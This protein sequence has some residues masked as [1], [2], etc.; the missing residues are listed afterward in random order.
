MTSATLSARFISRAT[1]AFFVVLLLVGVLVFRDYGISWDEVPTRQFGLMNVEQRVP[2]LHTLD[3]VRKVSG[4]SF[5]R[6]GPAFEILLVRAE[7]V[8]QPADIRNVMY[9]RHLATF[10]VFFAGVIFFHRFCRRRFGGGLSL[11]ACVCLVASPQ[12][13]SHAFYNVKDISFLTMFVATMLTLD[14]VLARPTLRA[15]LLHVFATLLLLGARIL[16]VFAMVLTGVSALVRGPAWRT[17][18]M[19]VAYGLLVAAL[20]PLV[21][22]VLRID[23]VHIVLDAVLGTTTNPYG[24]AD[25]F[26]GQAVD[27]KAL[28]WDYVPTWMLITTP[29][30]ISA[31]FVFGV[32]STVGKILRD[33]VRHLR[34]DQQDLIVLAWFFLPVLGCMVLR[35]ILYDA[36]RHLFFVYPALVYLAAA[37]ME[38][39]VAF[40]RQRVPV[41]RKALVPGLLTAALFLA[42][43]PVVSFMVR[44][45][46]YEHLYFNRLAGRDMQEIKQSFELDYWGLSNRQSLEYIVHT[47]TA[48]VIRLYTTSYPGRLNIAMLNP[49]DRTRIAL[50]RTPEE[51]EYF[52]TD[53]RF[54]PAPFPFP[55]EL[56]SVRVGNASI[57]SVFGSTALRDRLKAAHVPE[58]TP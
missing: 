46:P 13:F 40:V 7:K 53:Y 39:I 19:L 3:S 58:H 17:L 14:E 57:N 44:N 8:M 26:R 18:W 25:L 37:G 4:P 2:D 6:F 42:L 47:D 51:A 12:L 23:Y 27:A 49:R 52:M 55:W 30:I 5:E 29:M 11:L 10:L 54:H 15:A 43:A 21:W 22:P 32:V 45:H 28:P 56:Y 48:S 9:M 35:P 16:G 24:G 33:P 36:W 20:L 50:V 34:T 31:L 41:E 38:G 1:F